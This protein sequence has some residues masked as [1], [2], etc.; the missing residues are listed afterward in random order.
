MLTFLKSIPYTTTAVSTETD[1]FSF[2]NTQTTVY[3]SKPV[4]KL[5][6]RLLFLKSVPYTTTATETDDFSFSFTQTTTAT[7]DLSFTNTQTTVC[8]IVPY[9]MDE[10]ILTSPQVYPLHYYGYG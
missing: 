4:C 8:R 2:T 7:D 1:D 6:L 5:I 3:Y 10:S 9:C